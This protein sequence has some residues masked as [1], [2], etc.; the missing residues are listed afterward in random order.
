MFIRRTT[1]RFVPLPAAPQLLRLARRRPRAG[2]ARPSRP[3]LPPHH[4]LP[5][6]PP[7]GLARAAL[8]RRAA[9]SLVAGGRR[10][11][12]GA[13]RR[14]GCGRRRRRRSRSPPPRCGARAL[15]SGCATPTS[16]ARRAAASRRRPRHSAGWASTP[17]R[18][19]T[20]PPSW[21]ATWPGP[22]APPTTGPATRPVG[23][24]GHERPVSIPATSRAVTSDHVAARAGRP[25]GPRGRELEAARARTLGA[26]RAAA[27]LDAR[28]ASTRRSCR[29][30]CGT[31]PTSA[32]T[33]TSG[34]CG[35]WAAARAGPRPTT[36]STTPSATPAASGATL[37][38]LGPG[39]G[40]RLR[41]RGPGAG[42][43]SCWLVRFAD[44]REHPLLS[45][46]FVY[47]MVVQHEHQHDETM[48][49]ALQLLPG[50]RAYLP[51]H[52][53]P[54][55]APAGG[56]RPPAEVFVPGGPVHDGHRP[57]ARGLR[58]RAARPPRRR[59]GR[60]GSTPR[61]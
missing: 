14:R 1:E 56:P 11:D 55:E 4:A 49:A 44:Q 30:W 27:R 46:G 20:A 60:S 9:R 50:D 2:L 47:G 35:R 43:S 13:R 26:A 12:R 36:S 22:A 53:A 10:G 48:L 33:R 21:N 28:D 61:R 57:R 52:P 32:T 7:P 39:G 3:R 34:C 38:L 23:R 6:G 18:A 59:A 24:G 40:P 8:P 54:P 42:C 5:A 16:P 17:R 58:Q 41:R 51:L 25:R 45:G 37:A 31:S 15:A 19:I 29:R